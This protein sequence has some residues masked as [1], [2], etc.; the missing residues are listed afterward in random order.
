MT[1]AVKQ[2]LL[3]T[4]LQSMS[5]SLRSLVIFLVSLLG[6]CLSHRCQVL[7]VNLKN[8]KTSLLRDHQPKLI[9][10]RSSLVQP[11]QR[12]RTKHSSAFLSRSNRIS[13]SMDQKED[14][15]KL[16]KLR[17]REKDMTVWRRPSLLLQFAY[18][19][20]KTKSNYPSP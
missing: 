10:I 17:Y 11:S 16:A 14:D 18:S 7:A 15:N 20:S 4:I 2:N 9:T 1:P 5:T 8:N 13:N 6:R 3:I 19:N 12:S